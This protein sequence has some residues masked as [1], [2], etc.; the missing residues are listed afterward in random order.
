[1]KWIP[2]TNMGIWGRII[3]KWISEDCYMKMG[4]GFNR[5]G[6]GSNGG[7]LRTQ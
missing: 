2:N 6:T 3:S 5:L 1:M 7:I 4:T